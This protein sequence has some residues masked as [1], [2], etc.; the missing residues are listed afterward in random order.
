MVSQFFDELSKL[1]PATLATVTA[2][3]GAFGVIV[4]AIIT[5]VLAKFVVSPFLGARDKQDREAE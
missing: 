4:A 2:I 3:A 5:A 1:T